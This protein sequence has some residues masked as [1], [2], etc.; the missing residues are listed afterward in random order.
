[1]PPA[2]R[3]EHLLQA[4]FGDPGHRPEFYHALLESDLFV[5][6]KTERGEAGEYVAGPEGEHLSIAG[7]NRDGKTLIP[8]FTSLERMNESVTE[9]TTYIQ[10]NGRA[11]LEILDSNATVLLNPGCNL[12]KELA[13]DE[14]KAL[15]S[16][17]L[18][19]MP[20]TQR[21]KAGT[22]I[23]LSQP[24]KRPVELVGALRTLLA[25][26]AG[27]KA[28]FMAQVCIP[29]TKEPPHLL[30]GVLGDGDIRPAIAEANLVAKNL[31]PDGELID[32]LDIGAD[33]A[34]L[35]LVHETKPFYTR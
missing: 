10:L 13:P 7:W 33:E 34:S 27:I 8:V 21:V 9:P 30:I 17:T 24:A 32:F 25:K 5:I 11:L 23:Q 14:V 3:L 19:G 16:G 2:N 35:H 20:E 29:D 4:A 26:H 22:R 12:G 28:A 31:L 1:M 18:F 15:L 6:G